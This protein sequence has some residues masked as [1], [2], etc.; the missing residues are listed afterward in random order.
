MKAV[1]EVYV[2]KSDSGKTYIGHTD[3]LERRLK[4]HNQSSSKATKSEEGWTL[5]YSESLPSRSSAI[6]R[7]RFLKSGDGRKVLKNKKVV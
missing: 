5:V 4:Q 6:Q 2:L 3:S 1:Y 7:E